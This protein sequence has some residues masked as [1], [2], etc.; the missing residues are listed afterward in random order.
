MI[1]ER[2]TTAIAQGVGRR[3]LAFCDSKWE[4]TAGVARF[5]IG[6]PIMTIAFDPGWDEGEQ[7]EYQ[8]RY[9]SGRGSAA[10]MLGSGGLSNAAGDE[11]C[12]DSD[13]DDMP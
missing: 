12:G 4:Q 10:S 6:K 11:E 1:T 9:Q 8:S 7:R 2:H 13:R 5:R 3:A